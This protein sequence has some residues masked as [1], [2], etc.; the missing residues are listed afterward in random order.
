MVDHHPN[1]I[2]KGERF[3]AISITSLN[4]LS[5]PFIIALFADLLQNQSQF[6]ESDE[7]VSIAVKDFESFHE[8][9]FSVSV[10]HSLSH[11]LQ[12]FSE[13]NIAATIEIC[14]VDHLL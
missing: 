7:T 11:E 1:E 2:V 5:N 9:F 14:L 13:F 12:K 6:R 8:F 4:D 10:T 3:V